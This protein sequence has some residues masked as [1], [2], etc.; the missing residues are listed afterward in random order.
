MSAFVSIMLKVSADTGM[1]SGLERQLTTKSLVLSRIGVAIFMYF[2]VSLVYSFLSLM[3]KVSFRHYYGNAGFFIYW[4]LD[5][6]GMTGLCV[7]LKPWLSSVA[8]KSAAGAW[9]SKRSSPS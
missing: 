9:R 6:I 5:W 2:W 4:M 1:Q 3:F 8:D 7:H